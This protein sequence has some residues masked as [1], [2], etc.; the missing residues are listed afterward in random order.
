M[1]FMTYAEKFYRMIHLPGRV[2]G[3][4]KNWIIVLICVYVMKKYPFI[5]KFSNGVDYRI[6]NDP[7]DWWAIRGLWDTF[8]KNY[9]VSDDVLSLTYNGKKVTIY[10]A[11]HSAASEIFG[12]S[13]PYSSLSFRDKV[14]MDIGANVGDSAIFFALEGAKRIIAIEPNLIHYNLLVRNI[15]ENGL[16]KKIELLNAGI[17]STDKVITVKYSSEVNA[18]SPLFESKDGERIPIFSFETMERRYPLEDAIL[19]IDCEGCEYDII[20]EDSVR[21]FERFQ[22]IIMEY[23]YGEDKLVNVLTKAKFLITRI[24]ETKKKVYNY[25]AKQ[26]MN[27]GMLYAKRAPEVINS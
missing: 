11:S 22:E 4:A 14:I 24:D 2:R 12:N 16:L 19:K 1:V 6:I 9:S 10:G 7:D 18:S 26:W 5:L 3:F 21:F 20:T 13:N 27:T 25:K 8:G 15:K 17:G 23:H